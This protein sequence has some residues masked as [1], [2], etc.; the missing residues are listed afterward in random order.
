M[1]RLHVLVTGLPNLWT[2]LPCH[3]SYQLFSLL[4]PSRDYGSFYHPAWKS[5]NILTMASFDLIRILNLPA[6][7][8]LN[9]SALPPTNTFR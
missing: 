8:R 6:E 1:Q 4:T 5:I 3:H 9:V 7:I 2:Q